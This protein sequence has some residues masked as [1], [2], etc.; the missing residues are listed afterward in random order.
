MGGVGR[1]TRQSERQLCFFAVLVRKERS[2]VL[3]LQPKKVV[4]R[5][6][7]WVFTGYVA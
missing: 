7:G 1:G 6:E 3:G 5:F 2:G 4:A